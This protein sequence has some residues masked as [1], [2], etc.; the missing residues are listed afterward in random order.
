MSDIFST[1]PRVAPIG[2]P[3][4]EDDQGDATMPIAAIPRPQRTDFDP[5]RVNY[6]QISN[7]YVQKAYAGVIRDQAQDDA[8]RFRE[9]QAQ[10]AEQ[11]RQQAEMQRQQEEQQKQAQRV[12][13]AEIERQFKTAQRPYYKDELGQ[14]VPEHDDS[15]WNT[16]QAQKKAN[17]AR[18]AQWRA[19]D[20]PFYKDDVTGDLV[21]THADDVWLKHKAEKDAK[22]AEEARAT[23][24]RKSLAAL[25]AE[26]GDPSKTPLTDTERKKLEKQYRDITRD[27][28]NTHLLPKL[29]TTGNEQDAGIPFWPFD[30]KPTD[31]ATAA[32]ERLNSINERLI[33]AD[34]EKSPVALDDHDLE[35]LS[36]VAPGIVDTLGKTKAT[37]EADD[38]NRAW[39]DQKKQTKFE[40][41]MRLKN[42]AKWE[43][44]QHERINS[45]TN[46]KDAEAYAHTLQENTQSRIADIES[47]KAEL[48][49]H[50]DGIRAE[51]ADVEAK[52]GSAKNDGIPAGK[53]VMLVNPATGE[54]EPWH[55]DLAAQRR[56]I[57]Q[58]AGEQEKELAPIRR[59][60]P[61]EAKSLDADISIV[62]AAHAKA[63]DA[64]RTKEAESLDKLRLNPSFA[65]AADQFAALRDEGEQRRAAIDAQYPEDSRERTGAM[66]ALQ[67]DI[68][69]K[70]QAVNEGIQA[71]QQAGAQ[72]Y[73]VWKASKAGLTPEDIKRSGLTDEE[74][75]YWTEYYKGRD[76]NQGNKDDKARVLADG[77]L[78]VNPLLWTKP[79]E[80]KKA[81][82]STTASDAE[83]A[84]MIEQL[85]ALE[86]QGYASLV[87][88]LPGI[89]PFAEQHGAT[90]LVPGANAYY[91]PT[92]EQ[93]KADALAHAGFKSSKELVEAY[94]KENGWAK[95]HLQQLLIGA[96]QG[97][98]G[99]AQQAAG[100]TS[101]LTGSAGAMDFS[102]KA[103]KDIARLGQSSAA[104]ENGQWTA[105][106]AQGATSILPALAGGMALGTVGRLVAGARLASGAITADRA[107]K[108]AEHFGLA[109][110]AGAGGLQSFGST[111]GEAFD[112]YKARGLSDEEARSKAW[113]P[114]LG[115]G[116]S[117]ALATVATPMAL[118]KMAPG[119]FGEGVQGIE[120]AGIREA[121]RGLTGKVATTGKQ[122]IKGLLKG[123]ASEFP[124]E[125]IDQ[126]VQGIITK[127]TYEPNKSWREIINE[128]L[129]AGA[130][131]AVLGGGIEA[132]TGSGASQT[133]PT[134]PAQ[135]QTQFTPEA[136]AAA[137]AQIDGYQSPTGDPTAGANT[138]AAAK[139]VLQVAQGNLATLKDSDLALLDLKRNAS[140]ELEN[141]PTKDGRPP[142]VK[143]ENGIPIIS[144][145]TLDNIE[146]T[147]P[148]VRSLIG[149]DETQARAYFHPDAVKQREADAKQVAKQAAQQ[150]VSDK[151][152]AQVAAPTSVSQAP[153]QQVAP[154]TT[155]RD[156]NR[157]LAPEE[158]ERVKLL[159]AFLT[160]RNVAPEHA[161]D[162]ADY[163]VREQGITN[164]DYNVQAIKDLLPFIKS[165]GGGLTATSSAKAFNNLQVYKNTGKDPNESAPPVNV[166]PPAPE[167]GQKYT[168]LADDPDYPTR[169]ADALKTFKDKLTAK[170]VPD[171]AKAVKGAANALVHLDTALARYSPLIPN[172]WRFASGKK[173]DAGIQ[174]SAGLGYNANDGS[175][176]IDLDTFLENHGNNR[177]ESKD[178]ITATVEEEF[179]HSVAAAQFKPAEMVKLWKSLLSDKEGRKIAR[180]VYRGYNSNPASDAEVDAIFEGH[181]N[182]AQYQMAHEFL[183]MLAQNDVFRGRVTEA[184][185]LSP[186][187]GQKIIDFLKNF[188]KHLDDMVKKAPISIRSDVEAYRKQLN[189]EL[190]TLLD[191][192]PVEGAVLKTE[193]APATGKQSLQVAKVEDDLDYTPPATAT[194]KGDE[195]KIP[196]NIGKEVDIIL[197]DGTSLPARYELVE[198]G[199][200]HLAPNN[201][202]DYSTGQEVG[203]IEKQL[204]SFKPELILNNNPT[205]DTGPSMADI[206]GELQG[207]NRRYILAT[208]ER[209]YPRYRAY[210]FKHAEQFG[211]TGKDVTD[212][213]RPVLIRRILTQK[214]DLNRAL[215]N[216]AVGDIGVVDN[217]LSAAR[218]LN[219]EART[220]AME[221]F[222]GAPD[223]APLATLQK[224]NTRDL[225]KALL[226]A[227]AIRPNERSKYVADG[228]LTDEGAR[229]VR[230]I[231]L[232]DV[233]PDKAV[234]QQIGDTPLETK[235]IAAIPA[236]SKARARGVDITPLL[237]AT[238]MEVDRASVK[239]KKAMSIDDYQ[240]QQ[241]LGFTGDTSDSA[242]AVQRLLGETASKDI[243]RVFA[244]L[245]S[246]VAPIDPDQ[247]TLTGEQ[248]RAT[249]GDFTPEEMEAIKKG[250]VNTD[251]GTLFSGQRRNY[252]RNK[253]IFA[254]AIKTPLGDVTAYEWQSK[255]DEDFNKDGEAILRRVSD[256]DKAAVNAET[257][258]SI[259][260]HFTVNGPN[261]EKTV[262]LESTL[263][264]LRQSPVGN[265]L[266][267]TVS[268]ARRLMVR[269]SELAEL[270]AKRDAYETRLS[271][272]KS[273]LT[274]PQPHLEES[275]FPVVASQGKKQA[276]IGDV[277]LYPVNP[278]D[279]TEWP[280]QYTKLEQAQD[281]WRRKQ[282]NQQLPAYDRIST[283]KS[284][285][286]KDAKN[287]QA[288]GN[289][290][291]VPVN[292]AQGTLFSGSRVSPLDLP[293]DEVV[294]S[295]H[296]DGIKD[297][298][299]RVQSLIAGPRVSTRARQALSARNHRRLGQ[300]QSLTRDVISSGSAEN[301][302][303]PASPES[304]NRRLGVP[305]IRLPDM[306]IKKDQW[307]NYSSMEPD[308]FEKLKPGSEAQPYLDKSKGVVYKIFVKSVLGKSGKK[309]VARNIAP[310]KWETKMDDDT[311]LGTLTKLA[312][313]H[314][315]GGLPTELV[316]VTPQGHW[317]ATQPRATNLDKNPDG[318][319]KNWMSIKAQAATDLGAVKI[320]HPD[321]DGLYVLWHDGKPQLLGDL[322]TQNIMNDVN[323]KPTVMDAVVGDVP[324]EM[325]DDIPEV[326]EAV[327]TAKVRA[328]E[329]P[330]EDDGYA[331]GLLASGPKI[332]P[333]YIKPLENPETFS[334]LSHE[335]GTPNGQDR[336][337][338]DLTSRVGNNDQ[339]SKAGAGSS[340]PRLAGETPPG[341]P[342]QSNGTP[343][344]NPS[345]LQ[346][347][348]GKLKV[349]NGHEHT[350]YHDDDNQLAVKL[351]QPGETG[352]R[353][354]I[355][356][357]RRQVEWLNRKFHDDTTIVGK[358]TLPGESG[359]RYVVTQT[360]HSGRP[361]TD[362][363]IDGYMSHLGLLKHHDG[364]WFDE[365]DEVFIT[366][367]LPKNFITTPAGRV[368]AIDLIA[369]WPK[370]SILEYIEN[371][372]RS[373]P[374]PKPEP[375]GEPAPLFSGKRSQKNI[376]GDM[377][378]SREDAPF[379]LFAESNAERLKR[380]ARELKA[381]N[382]RRANAAER[383]KLEASKRQGM[384]FAAERKTTPAQDAEY[385]AAV[386]SGDT[387][388]Q[389]SMVDEAA[390]NAGFQYKKYHQT[391]V[392]AR[393][394]IY[395]EGFRLDRG[396]ARLSDE[397]VPD[398]FFFKADPADIRVGG[399]DGTVQ[400]P[401]YLMSWNPKLFN[402]RAEVEHWALQDPV[403]AKIKEELTEWDKAQAAAFDSK[404]NELRDY[405]V[406]SGAERTDASIAERK[407]KKAELQLDALT[408]NWTE[409]TEKL[410]AQARAAL[411]RRMKIEGFDS[412]SIFRD[413]GSFK[414]MVDTMAV[415]SP[416]QIKSADPVTRNGNGDVIPLSERFDPSKSSILYSAPRRTDVDKAAHEAA[417]SP[418][419]S[420]PEP[421]EAQKK[422]G[423]YPMGHTTVS[424]L[425]VSI[426]NPAG[427]TRSGT[428]KNG[429]PWSILMKSH[430]GYF[431]NSVGADKD[432]VDVMITP[433]TPTDY[434][435]DVFIVDQ[436]DPVTRKFDESKVILGADNKADAARKYM[437]NYSP[438]WKGFGGIKQ[439]SMD[440]FKTWLDSG[441]TTKPATDL[442]S[443]ALPPKTRPNRAQPLSE[444]IAL[445]NGVAMMGALKLGDEI[446]APDG[447]SQTV[448]VI[449]PQGVK[450]VYRVETLNGSSRF[451]EDHLFVVKLDT[452][453]SEPLNMRLAE[454]AAVMQT[455][456]TVLL[457]TISA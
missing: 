269:R 34:T 427:S 315:V 208:N 252:G 250:V 441:K 367:A 227:G 429:K 401:V 345:A 192:L 365:R 44:M 89:L 330:P 377:F 8:Q 18:E 146:K 310:G 409:G 185:N 105:T 64:Q 79:E 25:D 266:K 75:H 145:T 123:G 205:P 193:N 455:G 262:S 163:H 27:A 272:I 43:E 164:P 231:L 204:L 267:N 96:V 285:I 352:S 282:V 302:S 247:P 38:A 69:S 54:A 420:T 253:L 42:P 374:Q 226:R 442:T 31:A 439:M 306:G 448:D 134:A 37:L 385:M 299:T 235:L 323:G 176:I 364:A 228:K 5:N 407:A 35:D 297:Q 314:N 212:M 294:K 416:E 50:D 453:D 395:Q 51:I 358:V 433:G 399:V 12:S 400:I 301:F 360:W 98:V 348:L 452:P 21:P 332:T 152:A 249:L 112:A 3:I 340:K 62:E 56:Q 85:P 189:A 271:E 128:S 125:A 293:A 9:E 413:A 276:W 33:K 357:Y 179:I 378:D 386:E 225:V 446:L 236:V 142:R 394:A 388:K 167:K 281:N 213:K 7:P 121:T 102:S 32:K 129:E 239:G 440:D 77:S 191:T 237:E 296:D 48:S 419:N 138:Q 150:A 103:N 311:P 313:L 86:E 316:G 430:Y 187:L 70:Y 396:R 245:S 120:S 124:E 279:R 229:L 242:R 343:D 90:A 108:L 434:S 110:G 45:F 408:N 356:D 46:P 93:D 317:I 244:A 60:L 182:D 240:S 454:I 381:E 130:I 217:A 200:V 449:L 257:G 270:E 286:A 291:T 221:L 140:G 195:V 445:M 219:D 369:S 13:N 457:P 444:R 181:D 383:A 117:T 319:V 29:S 171:V 391:N 318:S 202:R 95:Q 196:G 328:G 290:E 67:A 346:S 199:D 131:G 41:E 222:E 321:F 148:A 283:L 308:R 82:T 238:R 55:A 255:V 421:T 161:A 422:A 94:R 201:D 246:T 144:Q 432:H 175:L 411:T 52:N 47:R 14:I 197:P 220:A 278:A 397:Q 58:R 254:P 26:T 450:P 36:Q 284:L 97:T 107:I 153:Q 127:A 177:A 74:A 172:G 428:D 6:G 335:R 118:S 292:E 126:L 104:L 403:Y 288:S 341:E 260:H 24:L 59:A 387:T 309:Y 92:A 423:N 157:T 183:R 22:E 312:L 327:N 417:T 402:D 258:R 414:R 436:V 149:M 184:M 350:V 359:P 435:G 198:A 336:H 275:D 180:T 338:G 304:A 425:D 215:N 210:L 298:R 113:L 410:A 277:S 61:L 390:Y 214:V 1:R 72:V 265:T 223:T 337:N 203:R 143:V 361:S 347:G 406:Q 398:A 287:I 241:G 234:L 251:G 415:F 273:Q 114:A 16:L 101:A 443:P 80:A 333:D 389:Q 115:A 261:G 447:T 355:G 331:G 322:H 178:A 139:A 437:A 23:P 375:L 259:V 216:A 156:R 11:R 320:N 353:K 371:V 4:T 73:D 141:A 307:G 342:A 49:A 232:A 451:T 76:F 380:E 224:G 169:R 209:V 159:T 370:G 100:I 99:M 78:A 211:F 119:V 88:H 431:K 379:N 15:T 168:S 116:L 87:P 147:F 384:L 303:G 256:W 363:E 405:D 17:A 218:V 274:P 392:P 19:E 84:R 349:S 186:G 268:A 170:G 324:Q 83:K 393:D 111:F 424:G 362:K 154:R 28:V 351:T 438:G 426:E 248:N 174:S 91:G 162:F 295:L 151:K 122:F 206:D 344:L 155:Q 382:D 166:P 135:Q 63:R 329:A 109:G 39:H 376:T 68:E 20:R 57:E 325:M 71:K 243:K 418:L 188:L 165:L 339:G 133:Q 10:A 230:Y 158:E 373:F 354:G 280:L 40:L 160:E 137:H 81:I 2:E 404:W 368:H 334:T 106:L 264:S 326:Q 132:A 456:R 305:I 66:Q 263:G 372:V 190:K 53:L 136:V 300:A 366:D 412:V 289:I 65:P 207:G 173:G 233:V 30:N 194:A